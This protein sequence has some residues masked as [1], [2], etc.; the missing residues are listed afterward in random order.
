MSPSSMPRLVSFM[1]MM[2]TRI[3]N[4]E[5]TIMCN[6][7]TPFGLEVARRINENAYVTTSTPGLFDSTFREACLAANNNN[8]NDGV[9][10]CNQATDRKGLYNMVLDPARVSTQ[11]YVEYTVEI[12]A[13]ST[14]LEFSSKQSQLT[15]TWFTIQLDSAS[16]KCIS[17]DT[18]KELCD[19]TYYQLQ[20]LLYDMHLTVSSTS[21]MSGNTNLGPEILHHTD[22]RKSN[23]LV[24]MATTVTRTA[25][26]AAIWTNGCNPPL[27]TLRVQYILSEQPALG[28]SVTANNRGTVQC[29]RRTIYVMSVVD[30]TTM[31]ML[32]GAPYWSNTIRQKLEDQSLGATEDA[33]RVAVLAIIKAGIYAYSTSGAAKI[34]FSQAHSNAVLECA[35]PASPTG[36]GGVWKGQSRVA[37]GSCTSCS[38]VNN[39]RSS[40]TTLHQKTRY[41]NHSLPADTGKDCCFSC[42]S[43][44]MMNPTTTTAN[45]GTVIHCVPECKRNMFFNTLY[46][47]CS[48]CPKGTFSKGGMD[49]CRSCKDRGYFNAKIDSLRGCIPCPLGFLAQVDKC[50]PCPSR[51]E[52]QFVPHGATQC[53]A[54]STLGP[55]YLPLDSTNVTACQACVAGT[56]MGLPETT[57]CQTCAAGMYSTVPAAY[58]CLSCPVGTQSAANRTHC[59]PCPPIHLDNTEYFEPGCNLRCQPY[60]SYQ[61]SSPY[62]D[63][64]CKSCS[65]VKLP[66][67]T[68]ANM[69]TDCSRPIPCNNAP[70][71]G[72][73]YTS[74]SLTPNACLFECNLG[75][76]KINQEH[77]QVCTY[78][79]PPYNATLHV[80]VHGPTPCSYDCKPHYYRDGT[81]AC[82]TKCVQ[83][84]DQTDIFQRVRDYTPITAPRPHYVIG[85]C[86]ST[87]AIPQ[88]PLP[89][90]RKAWWAYHLD[91][92]TAVC[93]N[94]LL[95]KGEFCDDGNT[96]STDGCSSLCTVETDRY[97]DCDLIGFPCL[98][99]CGWKPYATDQWGL[100]LSGYLLP[101]CPLQ[102]CTCDFLSYYYVT[103]ILLTGSRSEWMSTN[104]VSCSCR[105]N[106]QRMLPYSECTL[107]NKGCRQCPVGKYHDDLQTQ[108]VSCGSQCIAGYTRGTASFVASNCL[109]SFSTSTNIILAS[110]FSNAIITALGDTTILIQQQQQKNIGCD[111]C[112]S[113]N[114]LAVQPRYVG[115]DGACSFVCFKDT[116]GQNTDTD[117]YC[118]LKPTDNI[119]GICPV[120]G[121]C[122]SCSQ[123]LSQR[124]SEKVQ[125]P[126]EYIDVC[127]D[128]VGHQWKPCD[129]A[130]KPAYAEFRTASIHVG[131]STGCLWRCPSTNTLAYGDTCL[132][133]S[134][135]ITSC[136]SGDHF[137]FCNSAT[138]RTCVPC[139]G[140]TDYPLQ[141]WT[142]QGPYYDTCIADCEPGV[143]FA[144]IKGQDRCDLCNHVMCTL[145]Q[146]F[147]ACTP[148]SD[149]SC[150]TCPD[151]L[152]SNAEY[153]TAGQ[154]DTRCMS[155]FYFSDI[156][157][158]IECN[159]LS[160]CLPGYVQSNMCENP[161]N[162]TAPP[163]CSPC[164]YTLQA[165][166][167]WA[168]QYVSS[169]LDC[170]SACDFHYVLII[171]NE[172]KTSNTTCQWCTPAL[173]G[174]GKMGSC[175]D[176]HYF[177]LTD[178][179]CRACDPI[180]PNEFWMSPGSC[181][182]QCRSGYS[183]N[184]EFLKC[185]PLKTEPITTPTPDA[186]EAP[187]FIYPTRLNRHSAMPS[188]S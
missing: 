79:S 133:C 114:N 24:K 89:F 142:T 115:N 164:P 21:F 162:R 120:G 34:L 117:T 82:K 100:S 61:A 146:L 119:T 72:A 90:L 60:I 49:T 188:P 140:P 25:G 134:S 129:P 2:I 155:G 178:L 70:Q 141:V 180:S 158:C 106:I 38:S 15:T 84:I 91:N 81:K 28:Y 159:P 71:L 94:S 39:I 20:G 137:I 98:P 143:S 107:T 163:T 37:P 11:A 126:T 14:F 165:N 127:R 35:H 173:C 75:Y 44:Y 138:L 116:T 23:R 174:M 166:E 65:D 43:G 153:I 135:T 152:P 67:G 184:N 179:Q 130:S 96:N 42:V 86:G 183:A 30:S 181:L 97:W 108:C 57:Y 186:S 136:N 125:H 54:C 33:R 147:T 68:Y 168:N 76:Q 149:A 121:S 157:G 110:S 80:P 102:I 47:Y 17:V 7:F 95:E 64:G 169:A 103:N 172:Q 55:Y 175:F 22:F 48:T 113:Y 88:S 19:D 51:P 145:G 124:I 3:T 154:C 167:V 156:F 1:M 36:I 53:I 46:G 9:A 13:Q 4:G 123:S 63:G 139:E 109:N 112:P 148:R 62:L 87:D 52:P 32:C 56:F 27:L 16:V 150:T 182:S 85:A 111:Q 128:V 161:I 73:Y 132:P 99:D 58:S 10:F 171:S 177:R 118:S 151:P 101:A 78:T 160:V 131:A 41:C 92:T 93:G 74:F 122:L 83:L 104:L 31:T 18:N 170:T 6:S 45:S 29:L 77:C 176:D 8:N 105:N 66:I 185:L 26:N 144:R 50:M 69:Q 187:V 59:N 12:D 40:S 5:P